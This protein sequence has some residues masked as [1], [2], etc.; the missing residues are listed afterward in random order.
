MMTTILTIVQEHVAPKIGLAIPETIYTSGVDREMVELRGAIRDAISDICFNQNGYAWQ[1]LQTTATFAGDGV[2]T[3]FDL[4]ADFH[5][6]VKPAQVWSSRLQRFI[7]QVTDANQWLGMKERQI[8]LTVGAWRVQAGKLEI[9]PTPAIGEE[10]KFV[11]VSAYVDVA[12]TKLRTFTD[13][14]DVFRLDTELLSHAIVWR[15]RQMKG[16][17]YSE[18]LEDYNAVYAGLVG[19]DGGSIILRPGAR[20]LDFGVTDTYHGA[21]I[22]DNR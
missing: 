8:G 14:N 17:P 22:I 18:N 5:R 2:S 15:W 1:E 16:L 10:H 7:P 13:D 4:P 3:A 9:Y 20:P 12:K 6:F 19:E 21:T 11:Y